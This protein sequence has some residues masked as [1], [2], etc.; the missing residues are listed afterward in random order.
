MLV[1]TG[2]PV[3]MDWADQAAAVLQVWLGG[4]EM[5]AAVDAVMFGDAEPAGRLP[6]TI[7]LRLAH[8]P[9]HGNFPGE[10]HH[11]QYGEGLL[12]G[13]RW[14]DTRELPVRYP[15]GHGHG[16]TTF[17]WGAPVLSRDSFALGGTLTVEV[18]L[19]NTGERR[20]A[21]VVQCYVAPPAG[22]LFRPAHELRAFAKVWAEPGETVV[23][24][25]ELGDRAFAY[26]DPGSPETEALLERARPGAPLRSR[27]R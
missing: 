2:A 4:Q 19:T 14:Y 1:N 27:R 18:P 5:A 16:Y 8:N 20:G 25:L 6:F 3:T 9:S 26:W 10:N 15:F 22:L 12:I 17:E 11:V 23:A 7:P 21:E 13:Y 24:R